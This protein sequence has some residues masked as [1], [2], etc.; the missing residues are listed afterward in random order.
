MMVSI[1][2]SQQSYRVLPCTVPATSANGPV[3]TQLHPGSVP[4]RLGTRILLLMVHCLSEIEIKK[5]KHDTVFMSTGTSYF[6]VAGRAYQQQKMQTIT[7]QKTQRKNVKSLVLCF[8]YN[9][10]SF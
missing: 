9:T 4:V 8:V 5:K 10:N 7:W 3:E 2:H 6:T 1:I